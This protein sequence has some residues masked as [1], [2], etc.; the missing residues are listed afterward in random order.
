DSYVRRAL[1][2]CNWMGSSAGSLDPYKEALA[3]QL[4]IN[5]LMSTVERE[6][7]EANGSGWYENIVQQGRELEAAE[8]EGLVYP[9]LRA[10]PLK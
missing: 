8:E 10:A 6:A 7:I 3:A 9:G 1:C 2:K 5:L 4:R